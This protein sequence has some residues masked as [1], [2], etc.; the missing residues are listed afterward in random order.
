MLERCEA[1]GGKRVPGYDTV[2]LSSE[3]KSRSQFK[4]EIFDLSDEPQNEPWARS[5]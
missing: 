5:R 4:P 1:G 2:I 3:K